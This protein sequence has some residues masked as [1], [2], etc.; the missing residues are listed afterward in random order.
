MLDE[1]ALRRRVGGPEVMR[2]QL[3]HLLDKARLAKVTV[4]VTPFEAGAHPAQTGSFTVMGFPAPEDRPAVHIDS[5]GG[6]VCLEQPEE[7]QRF[8]IALQRLQAMA[9]PPAESLRMIASLAE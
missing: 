2:E 3:R 5:P 8:K 4:Q 7:V 6:Q 1:A 9:L